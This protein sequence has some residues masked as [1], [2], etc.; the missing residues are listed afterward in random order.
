MKAQKKKVEDT[1]KYEAYE[2]SVG[3]AHLHF[4][5]SFFYSSF[6]FV[7][8]VYSTSRSI[9]SHTIIYTQQLSNVPKY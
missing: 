2:I 3:L 8:I 4:L 7:A 9:I 5:P 6:F 1:K